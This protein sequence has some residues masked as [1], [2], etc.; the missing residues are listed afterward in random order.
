MCGMEMWEEVRA[1]RSESYTGPVCRVDSYIASWYCK[2]HEK[3]GKD[4]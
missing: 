3:A 2:R 4:R 1:S